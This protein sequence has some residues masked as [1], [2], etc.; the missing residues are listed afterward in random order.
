MAET[1]AN[2]SNDSKSPE[3]ISSLKFDQ[4]TAFSLLGFFLG[5]A[6]WEGNEDKKVDMDLS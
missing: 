6:Y 2:T 3:G 4:T 5:G 1:G